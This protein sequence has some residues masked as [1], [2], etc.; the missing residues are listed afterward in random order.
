[1]RQVLLQHN[2][3]KLFHGPHEGETWNIPEE[4]KI[5]E[6]FGVLRDHLRPLCFQSHI[7]ALY[8][9]AQ[10]QPVSNERGLSALQND[11]QLQ[12]LHNKQAPVT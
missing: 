9:D 12:Q 5:Q 6:G 1:M 8:E 2:V 7:P 11:E 3:E 4:L 10:R